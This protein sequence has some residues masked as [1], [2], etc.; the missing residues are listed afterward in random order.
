MSSTPPHS[1]ADEDP[2]MFRR[3]AR[4]S[5]AIAT[6]FAGGFVQAATY[7]VGPTLD[8]TTASLEVAI[9]VAAGHPGP[10]EIRIVAGDYVGRHDQVRNQSLR[11]RGGWKD[12]GSDLQAGR[13]RLIGNGLD[14]VL[15][16][17]EDDGG[18]YTLELQRIDLEQGGGGSDGVGGGLDVFGQWQVALVD[19]GIGH[20]SAELDGG[21]IAISGRSPDEHATLTLDGDVVVHGNVALDGVGG[22]LG[23]R[24][25]RVIVASD[26]RFL[27]NLAYRGGAIATENAFI[28]GH[29]AAYANE[30]LRDPTRADLDR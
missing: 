5:I 11:L 29:A 4:L 30:A 6:L 16:V 12:C 19:V 28:D 20:N 13:T 10:D 23:A 3:T 22:G 24:H 18:R 25:A 26:T 27:G 15:T 17:R 1:A 14:S 21:G 7:T 2:T 9:A 8:C